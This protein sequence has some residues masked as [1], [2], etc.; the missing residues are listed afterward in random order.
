MSAQVLVFLT[1]AVTLVLFVANRW[2]YD[3]VA[4]L[5]L[6]F[7]TITGAVPA[8]DAFS[9]FGHPAVVTVAAVLIV[10]RGLAAAGVVDQLTRVLDIAG[11]RPTALVAILTIVV[12][13]ASAFMNNVGALALLMPVAVRLGQKR[14]VS[15]SLLLMPLAFGSLLGGMTTLIGTPPNI[16][17]SAYRRDAL[18]ESFGFFDFAPVGVALAAVCLVFIALVGWRLLPIRVATDE[19]HGQFEV[20]EFTTEVELPAESELAGMTLRDLAAKG[21]GELVVAT[22]FRG[23]RRLSAP[24]ADSVLEAGDRLLIEIAPGELENLLRVTDL[25]LVS[26][27]EAHSSRDLESVEAVVLPRG[28]MDGRTVAELDLRAAFGL[29]LLAVARQGRRIRSR[30]SKLRFEAGDI[31]L[32][33]AR[34]DAKTPLGTLGLLPLEQRDLRLRPASAAVAMAIFGLAIVALVLRLLPAQVAFTTAAVAMVITGVLRLRDAYQAVDWSIVVLLGAMIPVGE[35]MESSGGAATIA[36][37]LAALG[38]SLPLPL[39]LAVVLVAA[40]VLSDVM[41]NAATAVLM[42]PIAVQ[43]A[44]AL[45]ASPDPFLMAVAVGAS[46]AFLTPIG[47]QSNT[48]VM[49]PGGYRFGDYWRLGLP[50]EILI[51]AIAVPMLLWAWP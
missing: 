31:V 46:C 17:L 45:D 19:E 18:G 29:N 34:R 5:A 7:L 21:A 40:M 12:T 22:I 15:P 24:R 35:A 37:R 25:T 30:L 28:R 47:H 48:L 3:V 49:G 44:A 43:V 26:E 16:I 20:A 4:L 41:N 14:G 11:D 42:A 27:D 39:T 36:N 38:E 50:L 6:L 9:G 1:L 2:R 33:Q 23:P 51:V 10:S 13:F 8:A 32:L